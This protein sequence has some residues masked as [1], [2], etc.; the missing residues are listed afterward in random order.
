MA[1]AALVRRKAGARMVA[2][3]VALSINRHGCVCARC[4]AQ[5]NFTGF[6]K[7]NSHLEFLHNGS[8]LRPRTPNFKVVVQTW[9]R[10]PSKKTAIFVGTS[11]SHSFN[12]D[13]RGR[14]GLVAQLVTLCPMAVFFE[15]PGLNCDSMRYVFWHRA[16]A[17]PGVGFPFSRFQ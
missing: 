7:K 10:R 1:S 5:K 12:I 17:W 2:C 15:E 8:Q 3:E 13:V 6:F 16:C 9:C 4:V 11:N 14:G